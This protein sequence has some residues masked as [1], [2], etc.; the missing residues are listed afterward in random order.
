MAEL[1]DAAAIALNIAAWLCW[2]AGVGYVGHRRSLRAFAAERWWSR[3]R[4]FERRGVW[5]ARTIHINA[6]KDRLPE[7]GA[8]FPGGFAKRRACRD[9]DHL[10]RFVIETRRAEWVHWMV[11][12]PWPVFAMWNPPWAVAVMF[13]YAVTANIPCLLV[14]R[15]NRARLLHVLER[16]ERRLRHGRRR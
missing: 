13:A 2:S 6:W 4:K 5:Y 15:Y 9:R 8:F 10:E 16:G 3:V 11:F 12:L 14:Q 7:L 1:P